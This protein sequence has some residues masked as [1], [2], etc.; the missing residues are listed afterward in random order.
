MDDCHHGNP[1]E[2]QAANPADGRSGEWRPDEARTDR[3]K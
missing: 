2:G 3:W 1:A